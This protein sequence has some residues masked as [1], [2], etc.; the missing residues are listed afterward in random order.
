M[1]VY[2]RSS[3]LFIFNFHPTKSFTDYRVGVDEGGEYR[4]I[5]TSDE[6]KFGGFENVS[7]DSKFTTTPMEWHGR[8]H[9]LQVRS[10]PDQFRKVS[11][12]NHRSIYRPGLAWYWGNRIAGLSRN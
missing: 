8:K 1:I 6:K 5:L 9:W 7:L 10:H 12:S 3:L 11:Q 4:I 2:E